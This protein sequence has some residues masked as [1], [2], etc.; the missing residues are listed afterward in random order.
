MKLSAQIDEDQVENM[1]L[2]ITIR[3]KVREW[4][5]LMETQPSWPIPARELAE[6]IGRV[7]NHVTQSTNTIVKTG[8][9]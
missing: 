3:L 8:R 9:D 2:D 7:L 4:R 6:N 5:V 1:D